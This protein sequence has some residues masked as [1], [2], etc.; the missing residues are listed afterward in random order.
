MS[1]VL[2]FL[3]FELKKNLWALVVLTAVCA[4]PYIA[5]LSTMQMSYVY[6][7][8]ETGEKITSIRAPQIGWAFFALGALCYLAPALVYSFK[9]SKR[10]VDGYY[11]LPLKKQKLYFVK[12]LVGLILV[13]VPFSVMFWG[14]ALTLLCRA[15]NPYA[16]GWYVPAYF[17]GAGL[18][19][20]LFGFNAFVYTRANTA[21]DGFVF[22]VAYIPFFMMIYAYVMQSL[23]DMSY[24]AYEL[25][26]LV[27]GGLSELGNKM[28]DLIM[29][30]EL[31]KFSPLTFV[32]M[33]VLGVA[34]Y[35]LLFAL[36]P[37]EKAESAEQVSES[38]FGYKTLIPVY[39]A[40]MLAMNANSGGLISV[41]GVA[42]GAIVASVA[43]RR[44]FRF[45]PKWWLVIGVALACGLF[46]SVSLA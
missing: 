10:G 27:F 44:K 14:G 25:D 19:V 5:E 20:C 16:M 41:C 38:W 6:E 32:V 34:G 8:W 21:A 12:T 22:M 43:F 24:Y 15:G 3:R 11:A 36:L 46:L 13:L 39:T 17:G 18:G 9:M 35:T 29:Q 31:V 28:S 26:F 1:R 33:P 42:V 37:Y 4:L 23:G 40:L 7:H 45:E 2:R 30:Y